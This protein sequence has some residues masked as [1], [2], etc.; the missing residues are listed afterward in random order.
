MSLCRLIPNTCAASAIHLPYITIEVTILLPFVRQPDTAADAM[1]LLRTCAKSVAIT[2]AKEECLQ[3]LISIA[4]MLL[5]CR[6]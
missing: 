2:R 3:L 4:A 5:P 6:C 1:Y